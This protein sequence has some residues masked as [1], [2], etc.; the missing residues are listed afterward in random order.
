MDLGGRG[1]REG[2][3]QGERNRKREYGYITSAS[4]MVSDLREKIY[5]EVVMIYRMTM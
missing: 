1:S 5:I 3:R 2:G 4:Q